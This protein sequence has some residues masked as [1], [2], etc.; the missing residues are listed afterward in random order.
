[1]LQPHTP[2]TPRPL[3]RPKQKPESTSSDSQ[4][5]HPDPQLLMTSHLLSIPE[6]LPV[7][8]ITCAC[9]QAITPRDA[10]LLCSHH[11]SGCVLSKLVGWS[12][13]QA[14]L[15]PHNPGGRPK[16]STSNGSQASSTQTRAVSRYHLPSITT[17]AA[18]GANAERKRHGGSSWGASRPGRGT[19]W[20]HPA[21]PTSLPPLLPTH[22]LHAPPGC[23]E[24]RHPHVVL[25]PFA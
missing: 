15:L 10:E 17:M 11:F 6:N 21:S 8:G 18:C 23:G 25:E 2:L 4:P 16:R 3:H 19:D 9:E 1:M 12:A 13:G 20:G 14:V 7:L 22:G 24:A 5:P